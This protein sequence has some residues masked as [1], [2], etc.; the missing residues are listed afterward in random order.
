MQGVLAPADAE[1][2]VEVGV[3][4]ILVSNHGGR[5]L[6]F[7]PA[8][9]DML[10]RHCSRMG[11]RVPILIDGGIRRGTDVLKVLRIQE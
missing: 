4:G 2:A 11:G 10:A 8:P 5:Q 9:V 3:D 6:D 1:L 7:S